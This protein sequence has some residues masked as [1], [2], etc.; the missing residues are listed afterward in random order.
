M[1][2]STFS[3]VWPDIGVWRALTTA[4]WMTAA[5]VRA[6]AKAVN[7]TRHRRLR[8]SPCRVSQVASMAMP[9]AT[10]S[11]AMMFCEPPMA[12]MKAG[13]ELRALGAR[14]TTARRPPKAEK[15]PMVPAPLTNS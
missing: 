9:T 10:A 2:E 5:S 4:V 12:E 15:S 8:P 11:T 7:P 6:S 3:N 14:T 1:A 13:D